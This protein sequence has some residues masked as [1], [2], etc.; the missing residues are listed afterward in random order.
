VKRE[1]KKISKA[2]PGGLPKR[3]GKK[4]EKSGRGFHYALEQQG[5]I[6]E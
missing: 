4:A 3:G 2:K 1:G 5:H 6:T